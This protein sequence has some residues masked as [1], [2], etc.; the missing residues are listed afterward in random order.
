LDDNL[1]PEALVIQQQTFETVSRAVEEL[2]VDFREAAVAPAATNPRFMNE[3]RLPARSFP[4]ASNFF[5][6]CSIESVVEFFRK[7]CVRC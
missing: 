1:D 3:R 6:G 7:T 2:P 5:I 4:T